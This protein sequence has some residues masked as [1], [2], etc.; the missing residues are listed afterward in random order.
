VAREALLADFLGACALCCS[1]GVPYTLR[2]RPGGRP[3]GVFKRRGDV[4][5]NVSAQ[6][7]EAE[8][9]TR[10]PCPHANEGGPSDTG[11]KARQGPREGVRLVVGGRRREPRTSGGCL[12]K[13]RLSAEDGS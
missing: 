6:Y 5:A 3:F 10:V 12:L 7:P 11:S 2:G 4:Q 9:D 8:E 13:A 1:D